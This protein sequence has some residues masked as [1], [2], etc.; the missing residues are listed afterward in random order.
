MQLPGIAQTLAIGRNTTR[1]GSCS[2]F[3][4]KR[5]SSAIITREIG[6]RL[7]L[8]APRMNIR[9][10]VLAQGLVPAAVGIAVGL[11]VAIA[12]SRVMRSILYEVE[13]ADPLVLVGVSALVLVIAVAASL[14]P[15]RRATRVD[16]MRVLRMD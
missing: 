14:L 15:A 3:G 6:I 8:G 12:G 5:I 13:P 7:A 2:R 4:T 16:P 10:L 1:I 11:A 9:R